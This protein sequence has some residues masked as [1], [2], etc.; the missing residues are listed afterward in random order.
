MHVQGW[1]T[2]DVIDRIEV[3]G[4]E[5]LDEAAARG[6]GV[7]FVSAHI[8]ATD[9]A[10]TL[11]RLKG[12]EVTSVTEPV[13]FAWLYDYLVRS[14]KR[15]GITLLPAS[16]AGVSLIRAL[17]HGGMV[18]MIAD[19]GLNRGGL[20]TTF[21]G[22]ETE[23]PDW[24][25]RLARVTGAP[26]IFGM[27]ARLPHGRYLVH[28]APPLQSDRATDAEDD[29]RAITQGIAATLEHFVRMYPSQ[30]YAFREM[31]PRSD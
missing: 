4:D 28:I 21:F 11:V 29:I 26:V 12:F 20:P 13:H 2:N 6:K 17:K 22:R 14:R 16:R 18:A 8:G 1:G 23:F 5:Y 31:W 25:A 27:A 24:P 30:W 7:I 9:V 19:V 10:A 3:E 15:M